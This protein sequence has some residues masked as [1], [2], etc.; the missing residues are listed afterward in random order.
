MISRLVGHAIFFGRSRD[1][2][3]INHHSYCNT[4]P[5]CIQYSLQQP[6]CALIN[7]FTTVADLQLEYT[8]KLAAFIQFYS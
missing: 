2:N 5:V 3:K 4:S 6:P 8:R 7:T 1:L